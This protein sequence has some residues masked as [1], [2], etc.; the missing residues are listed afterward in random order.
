MRNKGLGGKGLSDKEAALL[1]AA[2][3]EL[4]RPGA[5][6]TAQTGKITPAVPQVPRAPTRPASPP[7]ATL[8]DDASPA[9]APA[10]PDGA[11]RM[12]LLLEA[13]RQRSK[14]RKQRA[15]RVYVIVLAALMV[16]LFLYVL[17][18]LFRTFAR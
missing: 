3:R 4:A 9:D 1:A 5:N 6:A 13:E 12:A 15:K 2:R 7:P 11:T 18:T 10:K 14:S 8:P 17:I 16:P